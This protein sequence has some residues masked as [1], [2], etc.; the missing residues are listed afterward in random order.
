MKELNFK[1]RMDAWKDVK[2]IIK[3]EMLF[4]EKYKIFSN[5]EFDGEHL[6]YFFLYDDFFKDCVEEVR[7]SEV[8]WQE[9]FLEEFD[10]LM[11]DF[12]S[13]E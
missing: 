6:H 5:E 1:V 8:Q 2:I 13:E 12:L 7:D 3:D 10:E 11:D 4:K 9:E